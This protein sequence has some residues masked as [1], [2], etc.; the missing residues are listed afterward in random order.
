MVVQM[1]KRIGREQLVIV[2]HLSKHEI[3]QYRKE[4]YRVLPVNKNGIAVY[5]Q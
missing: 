2:G 5:R 1:V 3:K 4:G